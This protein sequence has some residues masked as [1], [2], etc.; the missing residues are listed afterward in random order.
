M[1]LERYNK[2]QDICP[3]PG[4]AEFELAWISMAKPLS[5]PLR[6]TKFLEVGPEGLHARQ[7]S[8]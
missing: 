1:Y 6:P 8:G 5:L 2:C 3:P 4:K 7:A